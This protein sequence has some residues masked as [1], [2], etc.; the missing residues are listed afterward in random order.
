MAAPTI[1]ASTATDNGGTISVPAGGT[2]GDFYF[3][4][5]SNE[6]SGYQGPTSP[7]G[8]SWTT[9]V[10]GGGTNSW[11]GVLSKSY[12]GT[13]GATFSLSGISDY[14]PVEC[15]L[16]RGGDRTTVEYTATQYHSG[17]PSSNDKTVTGLTTTGADALLI[18]DFT[19]YS[20]Y[21][22][23]PAVSNGM[24]NVITQSSA[25][26]S[27][28]IYSK[29][30]AGAGASG[31]FVVDGDSPS[32]I[33]NPADPWSGHVIAVYASGGG[34]GTASFSHRR[35]PRALTYR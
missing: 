19:S 6:G 12:S 29:T 13:E 24:T 3:L 25:G 9:V 26:W 33:S 32:T 21:S 18:L 17:S 11:S 14:H 27:S 34:G 8:G 31:S 16:I 28:G 15:L 22:S 35:R 1:V 7:G 2:S 10:S 4:F 30:Q 20:G 23:L 5:T